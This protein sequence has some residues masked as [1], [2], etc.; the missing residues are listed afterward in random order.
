ML[1]TE[2]KVITILDNREFTL[3]LKILATLSLLS[4]Y[5]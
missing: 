5:E 4:V 2:K 1:M 3:A